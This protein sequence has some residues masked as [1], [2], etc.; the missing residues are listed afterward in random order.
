MRCARCKE[1]IM[2][3][4]TDGELEQGVREEVAGHLESCASCRKFKEVFIKKAVKPIKSAELIEPP[5]FIWHN[6]K[7]RIISER[8][9]ATQ[10]ALSALRERLSRVFA[11]PKPVL[12]T[13]AVMVIVF[14]LMVAGLSVYRQSV[15]GS[16]MSEPEFF[17]TEVG[18]YN[19]ESGLSDSGFGTSI[20][21][22][23]M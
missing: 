16:F 13:A 11:I 12:A 1:L 14:G 4:Y 2:T 17:S 5:E 8:Q 7:E 18:E 19:G 6:I 3:D 23:F 20:E 21:T 10:S 15:K 22:F 9:P